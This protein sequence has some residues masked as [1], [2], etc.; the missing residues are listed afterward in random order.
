[1]ADCHHTFDE[2]RSVAV[3]A[4]FRQG[5]TIIPCPDSPR[6]SGR[7]AKTEKTE[8]LKK[9]LLSTFVTAALAM[10]PALAQTTPPP[11]APADTTAPAPAPAKPMVHKKHVMKKH[12][13]KK[14][15]MKKHVMKKKVVKKT[16]PKEAPKT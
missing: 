4:A 16:A 5:M 2:F 8:M 14:H 6:R 10:T 1:L 9:L 7:R 11:A 13:M 12:V 3:Q 15:V